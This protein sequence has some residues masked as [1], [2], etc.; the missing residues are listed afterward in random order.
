MGPSSG[1]TA[2]FFETWYLLFSM[3]DWYAYQSSTQNNKY[4]VSHK[5]SCFSWW[6]PHSARNT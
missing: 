5:H 1:E 3:N 2:V 4:I 6:W